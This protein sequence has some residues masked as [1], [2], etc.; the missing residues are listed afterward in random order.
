MTMSKLGLVVFKGK[1]NNVMTK[2]QINEEMSDKRLNLKFS[3]LK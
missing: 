1:C 3:I 2:G